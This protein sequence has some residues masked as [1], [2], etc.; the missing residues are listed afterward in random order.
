MKNV[1]FDLGGVILKGKVSSILDKYNIDD[2][3]K[4]ELIKFFNSCNELDY[5]LSTIKEKYEN[6]NF[7][8]KIDS[9]YKDIIINYY[10]YRDINMELIKYINVL[11]DNNYK[12]YILSDNNKE[13]IDYYKENELFKCFD[14]WVAS[15]DYH[16]IKKEGKLFNILLDKYKLKP[17][18]CYFVDDK[19]INIEVANLHGING[20]IFNNNVEEL[21]NKLPI[22]EHKYK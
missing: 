14:G 16:T 13:A 10:K 15:C 12:L 4:N 11:H 2:V 18:E 20:F 3:T 6:Y 21:K 9:K 1:I 22:R 5:G 7:S 17:E 8:I 19:S